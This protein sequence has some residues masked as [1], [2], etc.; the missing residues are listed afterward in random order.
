MQQTLKKYLLSKKKKNLDTCH[1]DKKVT[2]H[3]N[4]LI[5]NKYLFPESHPNTN[6]KK[7]GPMD[8]LLNY[9]CLNNVV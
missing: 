5:Y 9:F 8:T 4:M 6:I 7:Q 1:N 3:K 2:N